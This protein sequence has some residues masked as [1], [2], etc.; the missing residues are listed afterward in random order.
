M[1]INR[2]Q[3]GEMSK[4]LKHSLRRTSGS[5][6]IQKQLDTACPPGCASFI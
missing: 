6:E 5:G 4:N 1:L 3:M 2:E